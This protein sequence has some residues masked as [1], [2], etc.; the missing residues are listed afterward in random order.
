VNTA[1]RLEGLTKEYDCPLILSRRAAEAAGLDLSAHQLHEI[2]VKGRVRKVEFYAL[3][4]V[5]QV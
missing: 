3:E 2:A 1:A 4:T 5:P